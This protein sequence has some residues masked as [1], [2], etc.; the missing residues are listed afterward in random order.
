LPQAEV[1][2]IED[3]GHSATGPAMARALR[4]AADDLRGAV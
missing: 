2:L 4:R 1:R 3:G